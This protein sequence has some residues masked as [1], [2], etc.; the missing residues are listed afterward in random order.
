MKKRTL[1]MLLCIIMTL[2]FLPTATFAES[3]E[4]EFSEAT[5]AAELKA[6]ILDEEAPDTIKL[7]NNIDIQSAGSDEQNNALNITRDITLDLNGK[8][9]EIATSYNTNGIKVFEDATFTITDTVGTGELVITVSGEENE[10]PDANFGAGINASEGTLNIRGG[11]ITSTGGTH[12]AGIGGG[13]QGGTGTII[14]SGDSHVTSTGGI[15]G[16]GIG[17]GHNAGGGTVTISENAK[18]TAEGGIGGAGIGGGANVDSSTGSDVTISGNT[19][20]VAIGGDDE[21]NPDTKIA[22]IG[23]YS[24][25]E[26]GTLKITGGSLSV[27]TDADDDA[28]ANIVG[29]GNVPVTAV[30]LEVTGPE[31]TALNN[32]VITEGN[33]TA[34]TDAFGKATIWINEPA[35]KSVSLSKSGYITI[36]APIAG[37][38]DSYEVVATLELSNSPK[39]T[40]EATAAE[41]IVV[42]TEFD[43][44]LTE[45]FE[46]E[47]DDIL[48]YFVKIGDSDDFVETTADFTFTPD[49][50]GEVILVFKAFDGSTYSETYTV[51]LTVLTV[52]TVSYDANGGEGTMD[53]DTVIDGESY[54]V[55]E[56]A[57]TNENFIFDGWSTVAPE[58]AEDEEETEGAEET[59]VTEETEA[60]EE[61]EATEE[62]EAAEETEATEETETAEEA[63][64]DNTTAVT[65]YQPEDVIEN[66]TSDIT[67]YAQ[68]KA[69]DNNWKNPFTDVDEDDWFFDDVKYVVENGLFKGT[70]T[71]TFSPDITT[72]RGMLVTILGRLSEVDTEEYEGDSF[73]DVNAEEYYAPYIKWAAEEGLINGI[74]NNK[75]APDVNISRQDLAVIL[76]RYASY[77]EFE[78]PS[79]AEE[80]DFDDVGSIWDYAVEAIKALQE[81]ELVNGKPG[82]IFDPLSSARRS[83]IAALFHRFCELIK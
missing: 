20:V 66:V 79:T 49:T 74:G 77:I 9:L 3:T 40:G 25:G 11:K 19:H 13:S 36:S 57:F 5:D 61:T 18:V 64:E 80:A 60:A 34:L 10:I 29:E 71:T 6:Q 32:V 1:A 28:T 41:S 50:A 33:Y 44:D 47:D 15:G 69:I 58:V 17:G 22:A 82:N 42:D 7:A 24:G 45:L 27:V 14:I 65:E 68:W 26:Q 83:E 81:A 31:N 21:E 67:F 59:D 48:T 54:T 63:D 43:L 35:G 38:A 51:T 56:N 8:K 2:S 30:F 70:S 76:F 16:A 53:D 55:K 12:G 46:D 62:T 75:F 73:I 52:H 4:F 37:S 39:L 78:L 23:T 72:T